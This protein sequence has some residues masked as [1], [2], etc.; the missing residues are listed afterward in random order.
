MFRCRKNVEL[1]I[2]IYRKIN[3]IENELLLAEISNCK[4]M[5]AAILF[6]LYQDN[7]IGM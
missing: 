6:F 5:I 1:Y 3:I 7:I 2:Y 4:F